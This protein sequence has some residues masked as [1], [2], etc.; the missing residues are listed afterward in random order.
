MIKSD[1]KRFDPGTKFTLYTFW[2]F[3]GICFVLRRRI[4]NLYPVVSV[5]RLYGYIL[6]YYVSITFKIRITG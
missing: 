4:K 5:Y 2:K 1:Y 3:T 6:N